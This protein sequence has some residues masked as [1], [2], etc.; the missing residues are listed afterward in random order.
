MSAPCCFATGR[1]TLGQLLP[2][3]VHGCSSCGIDDSRRP[4]RRDPPPPVAVAP[5]V[6]VPGAAPPVVAPPPAAAPPIIP[7]GDTPT[8]NLFRGFDVNV[9]FANDS[10]VLDAT[11]R[12]RAVAAFRGAQLPSGAVLYI[13]GHTSHPATEAYNLDL[14]RRRAAHV[15]AIAREEIPTAGVVITPRGFGERYATN[16][17]ARSRRVYARAAM[18]PLPSPTTPADDA[19]NRAALDAAMPNAPTA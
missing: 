1:L 7:A 12:Q 14:S 10:A 15:A 17:Q 3:G 13:D 16:D 8:R 18:I 19:V 6:S 2:C 4:R 11:Q 9:T 5:P